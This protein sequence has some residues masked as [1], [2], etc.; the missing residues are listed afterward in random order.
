MIP[1]GILTAAA[2]SSFSFLLDQYPG[3]AAAYSLRKLRSAYTG[4]A[5]RITSTGIGSPSTDIGFVNNVLDVTTLQ[6]FVGANT[7]VV[8]TWYDQ[9]GNGNNATNISNIPKIIIS[10]VLQTQNS[11]PCIKFT[12]EWL[13]FI[14][15][16]GAVNTNISIFMTA[17]GDSIATPGPI[18]GAQGAPT[19]FFGYFANTFSDIALGGGLNGTYNFVTTTPVYRN[20]NFLIYNAIVN[21]TNYYLYQNNNTF[22]NSISAAGLSPTSFNSIGRYFNYQSYA[23]FSEIVIYKS[24]QTAN[25]TGIINNTNSFYTIF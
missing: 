3:A 9:S 20:T 16:I 2:T 19:V 18:L 10:G 13:D 7:A 15:P 8:T 22:T 17:K 6:T 25:R 12:N 24:D 1:V 21:S 11:L 4:A 14:T 23:K 5:I